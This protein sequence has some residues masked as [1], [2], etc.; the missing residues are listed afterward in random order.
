MRTRF[1]RIHRY[2]EHDTET[3]TSL[4]S[5]F[6][7]GEQVIESKNLTGGFANTNTLI[8]LA[9]GKK[10]VMRFPQSGSA[11]FQLECAFLRNYADKLPVPKLLA[12]NQKVALLDFVEG[13]LL[14]EFDQTDHHSWRQA[15]ESVGSA[16]AKVH[17]VEF[18]SAG[19]F[20]FD[21]NVA[22]LF[23]NGVGAGI[24][25]YIEKNLQNET[26]MAPRMGPDLFHEAVR[27]LPFIK[28]ELAQ[29]EGSVLVHSDFNP[30]NILVKKISQNW[31]L[32]A[33]LDWEFAYSGSGLADL[34]NF[35]R[36]AEDYPGGTETA[37]FTGYGAPVAQWKL[38][39]TLMDMAAMYSFLA[40]PNLGPKTQETARVVLKKSLEFL[41]LGLDQGKLCL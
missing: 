7:S 1:D 5:E 35:F 15:I 17:Q 29:V 26:L 25:S 24:S 12:A 13:T 31:Q 36:F 34:G 30:K 37:F 3:L 20:D 10:L 41:N 28:Q 8:R 39:S 6:L 27:L 18:R 2:I 32:A 22:E 33:I 19:F 14:S 38:R 9:S 21:F 11:R 16:L 40:K 23:E 4:L